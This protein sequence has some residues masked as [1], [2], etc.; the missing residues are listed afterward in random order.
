MQ[1]TLFFIPHDWFDGR[2]L[3]GWLILGALVF[4]WLL[5]RHGWKAEAYSF[6]PVFA[7][8][9]A[10][11]YFVLPQL[12][13]YGVNPADPTG[14]YVKQGLAIRGYGVFLLL[15]ILAGVGVVLLRCRQIGV[16]PDQVISLAFWMIASGIV[17][18]RLLYVVQKSD[19]FFG[20]GK[21]LAEA[22]VGVLDMTKGGLVVYGS[23][24]GAMVAAMVYFR[25][26]KLPVLRMWDLIAPGMMLGLAIGRIGCL[27]NGCCYGGVCENDMP[28]LEFPAGSP[29]Y[30]QQLSYGDL[31]GVN[32]VENTPDA[33]FARTVVGVIPGGV[34]DQL[35]IIVDDQITVFAPDSLRLRFY[36]SAAGRW[37]EDREL[38][39]YVDSKRLGQLTVPV[40]QLPSRSLRIHPTQIYSSIN[41]MLLFSVLW[42][43]WTLRR[44]DGEV[45]ALMLI[46]YSIGRF[47][48]EIVRRD[49]GGLLGTPL[50]ISQW[51]SVGAILF[52]FALLGYVRA[53]GSPGDLTN[54]RLESAKMA[55]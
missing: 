25:I 49:E 47:L 27:M 37:K 23:L 20:T 17:G 29:P 39:F 54:S 35:G 15:A 12:E 36:K 52:G 33:E 30:M 53:Y 31:T 46:F 1:Q 41:A 5:Y 14:P 8:V 4:V 55:G 19:E 7:I 48:L 32:T 26:A 28:G 24:M 9:A 2:L 43:F 22:V 38:V 34:A 11:I 18:A 13:V 40:K 6:L 42:F 44:Y 21:S 45:F 3:V 10:A 50:T 16:H 51:V